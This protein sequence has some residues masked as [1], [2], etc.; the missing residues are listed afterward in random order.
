MTNKQLVLVDSD[1]PTNFYNRVIA[2]KTNYFESINSFTSG[3][4]V[5]D[6]LQEK[7]RTD[8]VFGG[9]LIIDILM[10]DMDG[11]E[12][13]DEIDNQDLISPSTS[14]L[15]LTDQKLLRNR[16][17]TNAFPFDTHFALKPLTA[18]KINE[19]ISKRQELQPIKSWS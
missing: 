5:L 8:V 11:F 14:I 1:R 18:D 16:E 12:V 9:T 13:L 17:K 19:L 6:F 15:V 7:K 3:T 2:E 10:P 4:D